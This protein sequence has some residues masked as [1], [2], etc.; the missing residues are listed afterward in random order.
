ML[1]EHIPDASTKPPHSNPVVLRKK[2]ILTHIDWTQSESPSEEGGGVVSTLS[3]DE[4]FDLE[5]GESDDPRAAVQHH[6][7]QS[8][9]HKSLPELQRTQ[10][11]RWIKVTKPGTLRLEN[12]VDGK[13]EVRLR[14]S[15]AVVVFCPVAEFT[16]GEEK[17]TPSGKVACR[18]DSEQL[19]IRMTGVPPMR[20]EYQRNLGSR[21]E[22][23]TVEGIDPAYKV[24]AIPLD[25]R[26][27]D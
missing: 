8:S 17:E 10:R 11:L 15:E 25:Q 23:T 12:V 1:T 24:G 19:V 20:L 13:T 5:F 18:G 9:L 6:L 2:D 3:E 16:G 22:E 21:K 27:G 4:A 14:D 26:R 7:P